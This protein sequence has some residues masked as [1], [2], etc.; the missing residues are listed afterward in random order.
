MIIQ[1]IKVTHEAH[2]PRPWEIR[3]GV[4]ILVGRQG[5]R[6]FPVWSLS[7]V[8]IINIS[9]NLSAFRLH[10]PAFQKIQAVSSPVISSRKPGGGSGKVKCC[11]H[12]ELKL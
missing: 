3:E 5:V 11:S 8:H 7:L 10:P 1:A 12:I 9:S 4:P 6:R 2:R